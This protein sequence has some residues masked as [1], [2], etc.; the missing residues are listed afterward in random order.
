MRIKHLI[1]RSVQGR[2][3]LPSWLFNQAS[4]ASFHL[5]YPSTALWSNLPAPSSWSDCAATSSLCPYSMLFLLWRLLHPSTH[6]TPTSP[7]P[8]TPIINGI[9]CPTLPKPTS[10]SIAFHLMVNSSCNIT[11]IWID[12]S[13]VAL[14]HLIPLFFFFREAN[15][16]REDARDAP[17]ADGTAALFTF[18]GRVDGYAIAA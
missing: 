6:R 14:D 15:I 13:V 7:S 3:S 5:K 1:P 17:E 16:I 18:W 11:E 10:P 2:S 8:A 12:R 4:C 9:S